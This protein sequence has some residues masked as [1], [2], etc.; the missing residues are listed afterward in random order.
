MKDELVGKIMKEFA[1]LRA[2]T[3]CNLTDTNN[4]NKETKDTKNCVVKG[5]LK[6]ED[7]LIICLKATQLD[8]KI[9]HFE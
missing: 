4:E 2:K 3:C 1:A 5:K 6:F 8:G 7:Y 9:N